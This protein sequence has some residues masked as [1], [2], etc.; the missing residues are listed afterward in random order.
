MRSWSS[1]SF[2]FVHAHKG[3]VSLFFFFSPLQL[4]QQ[5]AE[6]GL[7]RRPLR[8]HFCDCDIASETYD[9]P[10]LV[11]DIDNFWKISDRFL[12]DGV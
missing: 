10:S 6:G 12:L 7:L 5:K 11:L 1:G 2:F 9:A 3:K 4:I 8:H